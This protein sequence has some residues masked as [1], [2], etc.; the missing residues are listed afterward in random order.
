M[1]TTADAG[2]PFDDGELYAALLG[3]IPYGLDFYVGLARA[4]K[5][6]VLDIACG[7]GR[8]MLPCL[9]AG[10]DIDGLD[11]YQPMLDR[12]R[13]KASQRG[14]SPRLFQGTMSDFRLP[15]R[16]ALMMSLLRIFL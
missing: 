11:L 5:G 1:S 7:T 14:L 16:Y 12:L 2:S 6:P 4:A 9:E 3:D 8:V 15:R 10:V 13:F